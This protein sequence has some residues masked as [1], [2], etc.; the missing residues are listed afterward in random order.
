M[1]STLFIHRN[2]DDHHRNTFEYHRKKR[3]CN[4]W[5][6]ILDG[7]L[8]ISRPSEPL[9]LLPSKLLCAF[10][11]TLHTCKTCIWCSVKQYGGFFQRKGKVSFL[12]NRFIVVWIM[13]MIRIVC[14]MVWN[15]NCCLW[16][17]GSHSP[18]FLHKIEFV[19]AYYG[20]FFLLDGSKGSKK[21]LPFE[22]LGYI[23]SLIN[24]DKFQLMKL[25]QY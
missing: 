10:L 8:K 20:I 3:A 7:N 18:H 12:L 24:D 25:Q 2:T 5:T 17:R 9:T 1:E 23:A 4:T 21:L 19:S 15:I 13:L 14:I 16:E 6:K 11:L 22:T